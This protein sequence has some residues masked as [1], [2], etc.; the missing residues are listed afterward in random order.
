MKKILAGAVAMLL[1]SS[2]SAGAEFLE[3]SRHDGTKAVYI[4]G[5]VM[6]DE[7]NVTLK[8]T[9][10]STG[11]LVYFNQLVPDEYGRFELSLKED[12]EN[13]DL[14]VYQNGK[15]IKDAVLSINDV[16]KASAPEMYIEIKD[17]KAEVKVSVDNKYF[18]AGYSY[19]LMFAGYDS[20][21]KMTEVFFEPIQTANEI[22]KSEYTAKCDPSEVD[23]VKCF[24]W[25]GNEMKP[26]AE[27]KV[28]KSGKYEEPI[29]FGNN[30]DKNHHIKINFLGDSIT[31]GDQTEKPYPYYIAD[32]LNMYYTYSFQWKSGSDL[33]ERSIDNNEYKANC[34]NNYGQCGNV[35]IDN[36]GLNGSGFVGRY[37]KMD[38]DA[39]MI[40]VLG[41]TNDAAFASQ[42]WVN[43]E[44]G[45]ITDT[46]DS[47]FCGG[48]YNLLTGI[49]KEFPNS[50]LVVLTPTKRGD[51]WAKDTLHLYAKAEKEIAEN[52]G[53]TVLDLY[54]APELDFDV[55]GWDKYTADK[56]HPN[57]DGDKLIP[58]YIVDTLT[59]DG[60]IKIE[61]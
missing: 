6:P 21:G 27:C 32:R 24:V 58:D 14:T 47:T 17:G 2:V 16:Y 4:S 59:K 34:I 33:V 35:V 13:C 45:E 9:E 60:I 18:L 40:F 55:L 7:S 56:L 19:R 46:D 38:K 52:L 57:A 49:Q 25:K 23:Y 50:K 41:G 28:I 42:S 48:F 26:L 31:Y 15:T 1:F 37:K 30:P 53:I 43:K 36:G 10:K 39:D 11:K 29:V 8:L 44:L 3:A 12:I 22:G 51:G 61:K 54:N 20:N 5:S